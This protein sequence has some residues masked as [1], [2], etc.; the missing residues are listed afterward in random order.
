MLRVDRAAHR[1]RGRT[2]RK[3]V[4]IDVAGH[5]TVV[6]GLNWHDDAELRATLLDAHP[7]VGPGGALPQDPAGAE[8]FVRF[9]MASVSKAY[10]TGD[11]S[12]IRP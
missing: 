6:G 5:L 1:N 10:A 7:C 11:P 2:G 3:Q 12:L 4:N 9:L 8:D